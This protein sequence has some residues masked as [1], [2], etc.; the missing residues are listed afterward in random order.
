MTIITCAFLKFFHQG[1]EWV[2]KKKLYGE[3]LT[4]YLQLPM[5]LKI[6]KAEELKFFGY[7]YE[8]FFYLER[9]ITTKKISPYQLQIRIF[10]S[11]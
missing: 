4:L 11:I 1:S 2:T 3:K 9:E 7:C 8:E 10:F 5:D 6:M